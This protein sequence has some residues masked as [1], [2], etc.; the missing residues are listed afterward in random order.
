[1]V[2]DNFSLMNLQR[3]KK[4]W[5]IFPLDDIFATFL[6]NRITFSAVLQ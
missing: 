1:M 6:E 4:N 5:M 2:L 3:L